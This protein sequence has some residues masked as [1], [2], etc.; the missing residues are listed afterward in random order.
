MAKT[1]GEAAAQT[2]EGLI[3][4]GGP[5]THTEEDCAQIVNG[6]HGAEELWAVHVT[7]EYGKSVEHD[8]AYRP[9]GDMAARVVMD[10]T[11]T[12][13]RRVTLR[14]FV[15]AEELEVTDFVGSMREGGRR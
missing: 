11:P 2:L 5:T 12:P 8:H 9:N 3:N 1:I 7:Y 13:G 14:R 10:M 15:L 6:A 4:D